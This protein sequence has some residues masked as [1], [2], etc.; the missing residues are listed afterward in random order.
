VSYNASIAVSSNINYISNAL[1][2]HNASAVVGCSVFIVGKIIYILKTPC[3][4]RCAVNFY[5]A[6]VV[7][8]DRRIGSWSHSSTNEL[9]WWLE[10][11][12]L[13]HCWHWCGFTSRPLPGPPTPAPTPPAWSRCNKS[14]SAVIY[15]QRRLH[16][17][18]KILSIY[19][20][21]S[22]S[23][24]FFEQNGGRSYFRSI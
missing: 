19:V 10:E 20:S 21:K 2:Y 14:G 17:V 15:E 6:G 22:V 3:A 9:T 4:T 5:N 13:R 18:H 1:A 7:T 8:R 16:V 23:E 11:K 24:N 12:A